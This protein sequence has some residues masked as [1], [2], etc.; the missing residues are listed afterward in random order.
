MK[1]PYWTILISILIN[2]GCSQKITAEDNDEFYAKVNKPSEN[3]TAMGYE[4]VYFNDTN[5]EVR[6]T[7]ER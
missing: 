1:K 5:A 3:L 2:F 7:L 4:I 6:N